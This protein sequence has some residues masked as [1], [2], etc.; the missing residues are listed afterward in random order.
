MQKRNGRRRD[1]RSVLRANRNLR[2]KPLM[3]VGIDFIRLELKTCECCG[4]FFVRA[5]ESKS[6]Y[7]S[8]ERCA[9]MRTSSGPVIQ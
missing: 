6:K 1:Q 3:A 8:R 4:A 7:C 9:A 2:S 5:V